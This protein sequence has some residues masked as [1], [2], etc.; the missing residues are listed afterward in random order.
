[1]SLKK[2]ILFL[3]KI[4]LYPL[5]RLTP[6]VNYQLKTGLPTFPYDLGMSSPVHHHCY[7]V[8]TST[9]P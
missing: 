4:T 8:N 3:I 5:G 2:R 9:L 7:T 6:L 1:M